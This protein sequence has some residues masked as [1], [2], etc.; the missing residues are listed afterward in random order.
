MPEIVTP[1][2]M[3]PGP[4]AAA[5]AAVRRSP[6]NGEDPFAKGSFVPTTAGGLLMALFQ[7]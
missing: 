3:P 6:P 5:S 4:D 2:D 7:R 1:T